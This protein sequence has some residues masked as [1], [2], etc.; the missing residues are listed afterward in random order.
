[1]H[2]GQLRVQ[3]STGIWHLAALLLYDHYPGFPALGP[4]NGTMGA[5]K[6]SR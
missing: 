1:M 5:V 4:L 2:E 6:A 3:E